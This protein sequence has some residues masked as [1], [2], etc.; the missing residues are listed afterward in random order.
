M[1]RHIGQPEWRNSSNESA[2]RRRRDATF[3]AEIVP[4]CPIVPAINQTK[5]AI[6]TDGA[7]KDSQLR[8]AGSGT[9]IMSTWVR[10]PTLY[11]INTWVWLSELSLKAGKPMT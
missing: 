3:W 7:K 2:A 4:F 1:K 6:G 10:Y 8:T 11:E 9:I 5:D